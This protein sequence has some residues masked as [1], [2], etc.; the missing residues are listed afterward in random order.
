MGRLDGSTALVTGGRRGIGAATAARLREEGARVTVVDVDPGDD[1]FQADITDPEAM[2][3]AV[4]R[5]AG[6]GRLD[7]CIANAGIF[8]GG[9]LTESTVPAWERVVR[10]KLVGTAVTFRAAAKRMLAD[11]GGGRLIA[12]A[13]VAAFSGTDGA[14]AYCAS[15]AGVMGLVA[16]L[17]VELGPHGITVNAIAPGE[18]E[19]AQNAAFIDDIA[20]RDGITAEAVRLRWIEGTPVRRLGEPEDIAGIFAFLASDDASF[21]SG[22]TIVADGGKM[23]T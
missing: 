4:N 2:D 1:I 16:C 11:G 14:T 8:D 18:I 7:V 17:A 6:D 22:R 3:D 15:K 5:A 20:A 13:S 23:V 9:L 19:T 10:V 12:T 21:I